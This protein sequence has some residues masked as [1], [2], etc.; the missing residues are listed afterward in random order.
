MCVGLVFLRLIGCLEDE[1][2]RPVGDGRIAM[3]LIAQILEEALDRRIMLALMIGYVLIYHGRKLGL[4]R[5]A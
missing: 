5:G 3:L 2:E 1:D 4:G